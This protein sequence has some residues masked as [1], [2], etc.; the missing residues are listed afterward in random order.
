MPPNRY[1]GG[2]GT[3]RSS[4]H[5]LSNKD[6]SF[7]NIIEEDIYEDLCSFKEGQGSHGDGIN[8]SLPLPH[9]AKPKEKRDF[10]IKELIETEA[11]YVDV[12]NMLK[13][14]FI[15]PLSAMKDKDKVRSRW[16]LV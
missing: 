14:N 6:A 16:L 10:C 8:S 4:N 7:S 5:S 15:M 12:L 3:T 13:K 9:L 1:S 11:N 2:A